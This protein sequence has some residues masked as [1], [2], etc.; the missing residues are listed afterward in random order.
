MPTLSIKRMRAIAWDLWWKKPAHVRCCTCT[1]PSF[2]CDYSHD[3][4]RYIVSCIRCEEEIWSITSHDILQ[5]PE[6]ER[7]QAKKRDAAG[8]TRRRAK[9]SRT[10]QPRTSQPL[11]A[12]PE[13][14]A[15]TTIDM[16]RFANLED[17]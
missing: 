2:S 11:P 8:P 12:K 13:Q 17:E 5:L 10:M 7:S 1:Y 4:D 3:A 16:D 9:Q 15:I 14:N 6:V